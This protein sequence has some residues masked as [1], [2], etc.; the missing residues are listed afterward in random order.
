MIKKICIILLLSVLLCGCDR[1]AVAPTIIDLSGRT[2]GTTY[3]L[4]IVR[5][6]TQANE[7]EASALQAAI[8]ARLR[9]VN[10]QMSTYIKD[11]EISRFNRYR[12]DDWFDVSTFTAEVFAFSLEI[13]KISEGSFDITMGPLIDVWGFGAGKRTNHVPGEEKLR[14]IMGQTGYGK[15]EVR[16]SPP[17]LKKSIPTLYCDL[18]AIAKGHG[19]DC[20]ANLLEKRGY[21]NFLVEIG[22]EVRTSGE[23]PGGMPWR[24][25]VATPDA[26]FSYRKVLSLTDTSMATSGD[27]FNYF[28][29]DGIRY[30]HTIEPTT[31]RPITHKLASV[32]V[33]H[34]SCMEADGLATALN[35]MG[36]EK[37]YELALKKKLPAFFIVRKKDTFVEKMTP[38]FRVLAGEK[39][40]D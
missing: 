14:E 33:I 35:V 5:Q 18:S 17:A 7:S 2:M 3:S 8:D 27:Y 9:K 15:L 16:L 38:Q 32:T 21:K 20:V 1:K 30:S 6:S 24:V 28:E 11:S 23:K 25:A 4:R 29:K 37:G 12:S 40:I 19:V 36:P 34:K 26:S 13:S 10:M 22:G 31:G 39:E